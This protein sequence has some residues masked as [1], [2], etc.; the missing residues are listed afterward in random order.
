MGHHHPDTMHIE[1]VES[2]NTIQNPLDQV[3]AGLTGSNAYI[4][5]PNQM[6]SFPVL[7]TDHLYCIAQR[8]PPLPHN[9]EG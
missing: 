6:K 8:K 4:T 7:P 9:G 5:K 3:E 2:L 1:L